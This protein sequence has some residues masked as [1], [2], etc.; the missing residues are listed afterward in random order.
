MGYLVYRITIYY[1][2][3]VKII[4]EKLRNALTQNK[5]IPHA[6]FLIGDNQGVCDDQIYLATSKEIKFKYNNRKPFNLK[7]SDIVMYFSWLY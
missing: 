1:P 7:A 5:G 6:L 2:C 3:L 4:N